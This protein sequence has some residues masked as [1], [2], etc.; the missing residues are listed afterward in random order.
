MDVKPVITWPDVPPY[1]DDRA[2][3]PQGVETEAQR[4]QRIAFVNLADLDDPSDEQI[5]AER[6]EDAYRERTCNV[7]FRA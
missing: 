5:E 1:G 7:L 6:R 4:I 2:K 3:F